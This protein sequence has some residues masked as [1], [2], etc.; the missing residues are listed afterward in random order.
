MQGRTIQTVHMAN[1][2]KVVP[3]LNVVGNRKIQKQTLVVDKGPT[4]HFLQPVLRAVGQVGVRGQNTFLHYV[5]GPVMSLL[6]AQQ[7]SWLNSYQSSKFPQLHGLIPD[8]G[9]VDHWL[10]H[11]H[12]SFD[13]C[14]GYVG[15]GGCVSVGSDEW[16]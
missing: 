8:G 5:E 12:G 2:N 7:L 6:T 1:I 11:F 14:L 9:V 13:K 15:R 4:G 16:C 3:G 10:K